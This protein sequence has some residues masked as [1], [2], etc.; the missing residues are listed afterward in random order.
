MTRTKGCE[1]GRNVDFD[2][3]RIL[4]S[5]LPLDDPL[6]PSLE[7]DFYEAFIEVRPSVLSG[8]FNFPIN[9]KLLLHSTLKGI[10]NIAPI[11]GYALLRCQK[12]T[13]IVK[14]YTSI[15]FPQTG[16]QIVFAEPGR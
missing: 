15:V 10:D 4:H 7:S 6:K 11:G 16:R 14:E 13:P 8:I 5:M 1:E 2:T 3:T 9:W 12:T